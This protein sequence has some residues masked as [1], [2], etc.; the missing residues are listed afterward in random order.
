M[1]YWPGCVYDSPPPFVFIGQRATRTELAVFHERA[2]LA[3]GAEAEIFEVQQRGDRERV[4][5]H[6]QVDVVGGDAGLLERGRAGDR[7]GGRR[8]G[9]AS[10]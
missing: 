10:R 7:A 1:P 9:R 3:L 6:Q 2:A 8:R 5:A 4:V